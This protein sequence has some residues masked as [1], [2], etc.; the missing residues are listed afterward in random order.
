MMDILKIEWHRTFDN[1]GEGFIE[2]KCDAFFPCTQ[3]K[4]QKLFPLVRRWCSDEVIAEL[5]QH[6]I[7]KEAETLQLAKEYARKY[8]DAVQKVYDLERMVST[9][10][11]PVGTLLTPNAL[12]RAKAE[13]KDYKKLKAA[14]L[15]TAKSLKADDERYKKNIASL[16]KGSD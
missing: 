15:R 8:I 16:Q 9:G 7:D 11:Y 1:A 13:L 2:L 12:D 5:K 3:K 10:K 4:A 6:L 14:Y